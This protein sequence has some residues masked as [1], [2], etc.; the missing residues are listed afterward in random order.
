VSKQASG[1]VRHK[2]HFVSREGK[3]KRGKEG[4]KGWKKKKGNER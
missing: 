2:P 4:K 1:S 3:K